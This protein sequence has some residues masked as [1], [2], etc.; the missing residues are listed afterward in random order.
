[1]RELVISLSQ[2]RVICLA[3][4]GVWEFLSNEDVIDCIGER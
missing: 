1:M 4:D 2:H 3:S